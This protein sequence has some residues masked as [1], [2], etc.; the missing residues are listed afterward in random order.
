MKNIFI[1]FI[2]L[3]LLS[4]R[5]FNSTGS[6][7]LMGIGGEEIAQAGASTASS[8]GLY[9]IYWNPA[10]LAELNGLN[11]SF[12]RQ[13]DS[14]YSLD[15][16]FAISYSLPIESIGL[17]VA[18]AVAFIPRLYMYS[19][20]TF[21]DTEIE[22]LFLKYTLPG[23]KGDFNGEI[24]SFT[25]DIRFATAI[26]PLE[27]NRLWSFGLSVGFV[28]CATTFGGVTLED[29][30]NY[31]YLS[32]IAKAV[33]LNLGSKIYLNDSLTL[34]FGIKNIGSTLTIETESTYQNN[35]TTQ[36]YSAEFP[37]DITAGISWDADETL[38]FAIDY[39][40]VVG[41]YSIYYM[42]FRFLRLGGTYKTDLLNYHFGAIVPLYIYSDKIDTIDFK[43]PF[44]PTLGLGW[45]EENFSVSMAFYFH[46]IMS[47]FKNAPSPSLDISLNYHF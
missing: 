30:S 7:L 9:S 32:T 40:Q 18:F 23:L 13:L 36:N 1:F 21:Y 35:T 19:D 4:G 20:G 10:G 33:S 46:P 3:T 24:N 31:R 42:D 38:L 45:H 28:N 25:Y 27:E 43:Y 8:K 44:A 41:T 6:D 26:T 17:K 14:T 16:F 5:D 34:G 29:P 11:V 39:Q 2:F 37:L 12:S 47:L 22:T 15:N